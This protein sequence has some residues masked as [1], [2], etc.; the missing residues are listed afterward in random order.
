MSMTPEEARQKYLKDRRERDAAVK[1]LADMGYEA[2]HEI[3]GIYMRTE[4]ATRLVADLKRLNAL[5]N[6]WTHSDTDED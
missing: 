5:K 3:I 6:K 2:S 4:A 1:Q